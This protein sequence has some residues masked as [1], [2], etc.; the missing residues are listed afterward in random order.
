VF[1]EA[2]FGQKYIIRSD[3]G[4][5]KL[6]PT[7]PICPDLSSTREAKITSTEVLTSFSNATSHDWC[8]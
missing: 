3:F 4:R 2:L 6:A 5:K 8:D 7:T 1:P